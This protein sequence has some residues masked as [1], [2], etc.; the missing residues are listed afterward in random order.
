MKKTAYQSGGVLAANL[1]PEPINHRPVQSY[2]KTKLFTR[3]VTVI[4][5]SLIFLCAQTLSYVHT[6]RLFELH[7][8]RGWEAH[9]GVIMFEAVFFLGAFVTMIFHFIGEKPGVPVRLATFLG[10]GFVTWSNVS[11]GMEYGAGGIVIGIS[12]ILCVIVAELVAGRSILHTGSKVP[13]TETSHSDREGVGEKTSHSQV[14]REDEESPIYEMWDT[15]EEREGEMDSVSVP[16]ANYAQ[17]GTDREDLGEDSPTAEMANWEKWG[18]L[19]DPQVPIDQVGASREDGQEGKTDQTEELESTWENVGMEPSPDTVEDTQEDEKP[20]TPPTSKLKGREEAVAAQ[21]EKTDWVENNEPE[22]E[23]TPT[24]AGEDREEKGAP[25]DRGDGQEDQK[26]EEPPK[27]PT[28][29]EVRIKALEIWEAEKELPSRRRLT[30]EMNLKSDWIP[31]KV[32][33]ALEVELGVE[34]AS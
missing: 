1:D 18:D 4:L 12:I 33:E 27:P 32:L 19:G 5:G 3:W 15:R 13:E 22:K 20:L 26:E 25:T 31:R 17:M 24:Q 9:L 21:E 30:R 6:L 14:M 23:T 34:K 16:L 10:A 28:R 11:Y 7:G 2:R 29:E 8:Y